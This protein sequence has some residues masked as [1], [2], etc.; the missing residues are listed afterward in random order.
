[1]LDVF[2][3]PLTS[4][5]LFKSFVILRIVSGM[6]WIYIMLIRS[7]SFKWFEFRKMCEHV[8]VHMLQWTSCHGKCD[9][10]LCS[11]QSKH[12]TTMDRNDT[13]EIS[14]RNNYEFKMFTSNE[15]I[16]VCWGGSIRLPAMGW[17]DMGWPYLA[18]SLY[19]PSPC[20]LSIQLLLNSR[21]V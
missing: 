3:S 21:D 6:G 9:M 16:L 15:E 7:K 4:S 20:Q 17:S 18:S 11:C 13:N 12:D 8:I 19:Q 1:M 10:S 2:S 5:V 14:K